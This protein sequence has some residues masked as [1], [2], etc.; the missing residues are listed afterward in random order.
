LKHGNCFGVNASDGNHYRIVNFYAENLEH[1]V[2]EGLISYPIEMLPLDPGVAGI[3]DH[4]IPD[5]YY[6]PEFCE[7]CCPFN[8]LP[9]PQRLRRDRGVRAGRIKLVRDENGKV[10]L[11]SERVVCKKQKLDCTWSI[12]VSPDFVPVVGA[13]LLRELAGKAIQEEKE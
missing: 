12:E 9:H 1:L 4:R 11:V 5:D 13:G 7:V 8:L 2:D 6:R 10:V 3:H